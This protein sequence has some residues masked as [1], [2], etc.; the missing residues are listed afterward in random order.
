MASFR[1]QMQKL[2]DNIAR[3]RSERHTFVEQNQ[4]GRERMR[5]EVSQQRD[6]TKREL[7]KQSRTLIRSLN[8]FNRNNQ[9]AVA[10]SLKDTR[11]SRMNQAKAMKHSLRQ[12][13]ARNSRN[14]ARLLRQNNGDRKRLHRQHLR[15]STLAIQSVKKQVQRIRTA[16]NRT[17]R[18]LASDRQEARQI[19]ARLLSG[20]PVARTNDRS[21]D[22][23]IV[24]RSI[25]T[26][27][28][29]VLPAVLPTASPA[30]VLA[31]NPQSGPS[32]RTATQTASAL[33][34]LSGLALPP[35]SRLSN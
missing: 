1:E 2:A 16:T 15:D 22:R 27:T 13:I 30:P 20:N 24:D 4:K 12:E 18:A 25:A 17:T 11:Q 8:D 32:L 6:Q 14:V 19:W 21:N 35:T 26:A 29:A 23:S 33:S 5:V 28:A 34:S 9:K 7:A 10:R 3:T 31:T